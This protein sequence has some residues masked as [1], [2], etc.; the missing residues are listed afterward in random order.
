MIPNRS[1]MIYHPGT[2]PCRA[3]SSGVRNT[4]G[5]PHDFG[6]SSWSMGRSVSGEA[7]TELAHATIK[8]LVA[9]VAKVGWSALM[10]WCWSAI[11][12]HEISILISYIQ[13]YHMLS[14]HV[15]IVYYISSG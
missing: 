5:N 10:L 9:K 13:L 3:G 11:G 1:D 7:C 8:C 14:Y 6:E 4:R 12:F 2:V 15:I